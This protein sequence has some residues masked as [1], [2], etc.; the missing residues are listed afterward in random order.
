LRRQL[1][2][3]VTAL[4]VAGACTEGPIPGSADTATTTTQARAES[5]VV[6][7]DVT[8]TSSGGLPSTT[9]VAD[10]GSVVA[11]HAGR[12]WAFGVV[13]ALATPADSSADPIVVGVINQENTPIGSFPE[14]RRAMEAATA[15]INAELGGAGG[16]PIR[17]ETCITSFSVEQ[18]QACAQQMVQAGAVAV[19]SGIDITATGSLPVL[20]QNGIPLVSSLPTTLAELRSANVFSFSGSITGA[21]VAFVADAHAKGARSI[22]IAY[23]DFESFSVPATD[24]AARVAESLGMTVTLIPFPIT[25]TDFLPIVTTAINS[26]ADAITVAAADSACLPLMTSIHDL[27]YEGRAYIVGACAAAEIIA[28]VPDEVQAPIIFNSEG[29]F[30]ASTD[31]DLFVAVTDRYADAAAGGAGTIGFRAA[32]NLW[33][34][35]DRI[36]GVITPESIAAELRAG[37]DAPSFWGHPYTCDGQQVPGF[38]ALCS[39]QATL[40][41][42]PDDVGAVVQESDGWIDVPALVAG[43]A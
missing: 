28:Q 12:A 22:A 29:T 18:S 8:T 19:L 7:A 43:L 23:G 1:L 41:R 34:V 20:E 31:G 39:P 27:G 4:A 25:T 3:V 14:I 13:P 38:P 21:Y 35:L 6:D 36:D 40:F 24:Y 26:G 16:R 9:A 32:M 37:K 2:A 15:W 33:A 42:L 30:D 11:A 5:T 10:D 17:L